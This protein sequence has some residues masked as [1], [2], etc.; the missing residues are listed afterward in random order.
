MSAISSTPSVFEF[1]PSHIE[2]QEK[3]IYD[4]L[5]NYDYS[6]GTHEVLCS[7]SVGSG[8]S[9]PA[10]HLGVR[11]CL[12]NQNA[13]L[14]LGRKALPDLKDTIFRKILDHLECEQLVLGRDYWVNETSA[15]IRFRNGSEVI[16]RSW[17]DRKY[18]KLGSLELSAAIIE[19]LAENDDDDEQ[20]YEF[21]K[22][23]VGRLPHIKKSWI[24]SCSNPDAPDHWAYRR[25]IE[26]KNEQVHVYYSL[27][28][29]NPFLPANYKESLLKD[30]DP[31]LA[32]R[33]IYG[34][35]VSI[36]GQV[37]YHQYQKE[38]N[39]IDKDYQIDLRHPIRISW[40]FNI[41]EGKP[42][43]LVLL[44]IIKDTVHIFAEVIIEGMRTLDSCEELADKGYLDHNVLY[45]L[46][47]DGTGRHRDTRGPMDDWDIIVKFFN[48]YINKRGE[49]IN[50]EKKV[51]AANPRVRERHNKM[52][53]YMC[54]SLGERRMLVY[55]GCETVDKGL[56]L[57]KLKKNGNYIEDDSKEYQHVTTALGYSLMEYIHSKTY[58]PSGIDM[59]RRQF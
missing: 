50:F 37:I 17:S 58:K 22:M 2:W 21:I 3:L 59:L 51:P 31:M 9:L 46:N 30:M 6:L 29:H 33:M 13:R 47:G 39:Y 52:N 38:Y 26:S 1:D 19:E 18:K 24:I 56:R 16:S 5:N 45:I 40:D 25:L 43:S 8:K 36:S 55:K 12:E 14:L 34:K 4:V 42:M 49:N 28:E 7:G 35:W 11:H 41:G 57:T 32:Q 23:R 48:N 53:A 20:A 27:L 54:N 44:Q 15:K 10:A